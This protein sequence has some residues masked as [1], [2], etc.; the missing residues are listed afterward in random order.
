MHQQIFIST[1]IICTQIFVTTIKCLTSIIK[2]RTKEI[3]K[4]CAHF[5]LH[6]VIDA[7][8]LL[9][10]FPYYPSNSPIFKIKNHS[11]TIDLQYILLR[12]NSEY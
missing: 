5:V 8:D 12:N 9:T 4:K 7:A 6:G 2:Q 11:T 10:V 3:L 1:H